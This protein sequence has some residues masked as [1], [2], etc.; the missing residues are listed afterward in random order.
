M[1][2]ILQRKFVLIYSSLLDLRFQIDKEI[3]IGKK[4]KNSVEQGDIKG[5]DKVSEMLNFCMSLILK[6]KIIKFY[7][8]F[9]IIFL[10]FNIKF[11]V[12]EVLYVF[13]IKNKENISDKNLEE[14]LEFLINC[15]S[16]V[17]YFF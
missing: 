1:K 8:Y 7:C 9:K 17:K 10:D 6:S 5:R 3:V 11:Y 16:K 15:I 4:K 13:L 14:L 12:F 2:P